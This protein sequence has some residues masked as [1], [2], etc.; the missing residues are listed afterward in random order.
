MRQGERITVVSLTFHLQCSELNQVDGII[1]SSGR[2]GFS[3]FS[4]KPYSLVPSA[5]VMCSLTYSIGDLLD[6]CI[7]LRVVADC[8]SVASHLQ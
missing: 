1:I 2:Q 8:R 5:F 6:T 7:C 4:L 3:L